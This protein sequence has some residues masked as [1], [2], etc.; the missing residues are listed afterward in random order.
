MCP[1]IRRGWLGLLKMTEGWKQWEGQAV[2]R[3]FGLRQYLGGSDHSAV[4]LTG[5]GKQEP[6]R[7][8]IKLIPASLEQAEVQL[9]RWNIASTLSHPHLIRLF[10]TGRCVLSNTDLL[11]VVMEYA[12]EDLSQV[13]LHRSLTLA[14]AQDM[15]SPALDV[16]AYLHAKGLVHGHLKPANIMAVDNQLKISSDQLLQVR[17]S[18]GSAGKLSPYDAPEIASRGVSPASDV[19]SLGITLVESL[20]QQLPPWEQTRQPQAALPKTLPQPFLDIASHCLHRNP[21]FRW[22]VVDIRARLQPTP[23][24]SNEQTTTKM[25]RPSGKWRYLVTA[26]VGFALLAI[27]AGPRLFKP[28]P[29]PRLELAQGSVSAP[30]QPRTK[31]TG[32]GHVEGAVISQVVPDVPKQARDTIQGTVRVTVSIAVDSSGNVVGAKIDLPGPSRYFA[33]LALESARGWTFRPAEVDGRNVSSEWILRFQ[34]E[35]AGTKVLPV[36]AVP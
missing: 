18:I 4:F 36:Q 26:A 30:E 1:G 21:E 3:K 8:I 7:A 34:F 17:E 23:S 22:T 13:L 16:L 6:Q 31:T 12:E 20:T 15:L 24:V 25:P 32:G 35:R 33:N 11:Y 2:E 29:N 27:L 28:R 10:Q 9:S 5:F 19:W 14:E